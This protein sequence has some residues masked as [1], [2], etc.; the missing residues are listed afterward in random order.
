MW[1]E[2]TLQLKLAQGPRD[3]IK[4]D[5]QHVFA[6]LLESG[7]RSP[8]DNQTVCAQQNMHPFHNETI[9]DAIENINVELIACSYSS[10]SDVLDSSK[11]RLSCLMR[12][13]AY[14]YRE[15]QHMT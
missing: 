15:F 2:L 4:Q 8:L 11:N 14:V 10:V 12:F 6:N 3:K 9:H 13:D 7:I 5:K 1:T